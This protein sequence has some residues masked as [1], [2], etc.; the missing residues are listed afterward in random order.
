MNREQM[1]RVLTVWNERMEDAETR[2]DELTALIGSTP[3]APLQAAVYGLMGAYTEATAEVLGICDEWLSAWWLEHGF[4]ARPMQAG[5]VGEPLRTICT[6]GDLL[7]LIVGDI[8]AADAEA[9]ES[10]DWGKP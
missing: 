8:A 2:M 9:R 6:L 1:L 7:D 5:L 3:E 4:G 10:A